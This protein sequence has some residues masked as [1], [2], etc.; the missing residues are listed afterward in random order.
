MVV[1][2]IDELNKARRWRFV[3]LFDLNRENTLITPRQGGI[4]KML[5]KIL[6]VDQE[7]DSL[8]L[9]NMLITDYT[10]YETVSTNNPWEALALAGEGGIDLVITRMKM[11]GLDGIELLEQIKRIN[12]SIP[13]IIVSSSGSVE[14]ALEIMR[15]GGFEFLI[16]P[17]RKEQMLFAIGNALTWS[18]L[19]RENRMLKEQLLRSEIPHP[20]WIRRS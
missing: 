6:I 18:R 3:A 10:A 5:E 15:K 17:Y 11:P 14:T 13:V 19:N 9:L 2:M 1:G 4:R 16:T 20:F 12:E 7:P 8:V